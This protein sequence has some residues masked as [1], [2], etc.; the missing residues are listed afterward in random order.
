MRDTAKTTA[1]LQRVDRTLMLHQHNEMCLSVLPSTAAW[2]HVCTATA[3][4]RRL[5]Q[6][7]LRNVTYV[8]AYRCVS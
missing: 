7:T 2:C 5:T 1:A 4:Q 3:I 6:S 8:C